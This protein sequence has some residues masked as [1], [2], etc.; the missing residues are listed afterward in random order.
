MTRLLVLP[1]SV[2]A[3]A[4]VTHTCTRTA[5]IFDSMAGS[6]G[7]ITS[8]SASGGKTLSI[9]TDQPHP[10][11]VRDPTM[12]RTSPCAGPS[13][14][15]ELIFI[16]QALN[17]AEVHDAHARYRWP[18]S[19]RARYQV[20]DDPAWTMSGSLVGNRRNG[21]QDDVV[22]GSGS[23]HGGR[24]MADNRGEVVMGDTEAV[25]SLVRG[26]DRCFVG[27]A[28]HLCHQE[29][30]VSLEPGKVDL[31]KVRRKLGSPNTRS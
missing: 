6:S 28:E 14:R 18:G 25:V 4:C 19:S 1:G 20:T 29:H 21:P 7:F 12:I 10:N 23:L 16:W 31:F 13:L 30:L 11:Q 17:V 27:A 26:G 5:G 22:P 15:Y 9:K 2:P 24:K 8:C 3:G